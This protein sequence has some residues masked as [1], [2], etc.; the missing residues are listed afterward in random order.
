MN[1]FINQ[2]ER[3][4]WS[5]FAVAAMKALPLASCDE[6]T[7]VADRM[8]AEWR[9]RNATIQR[10]F[11]EHAADMQRLLG[12]VRKMRKAADIDDGEKN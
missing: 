7:A 1:E 4:A 12:E 5:A 6:W 2:A 10:A 9:K 8:L 11:D 3:E